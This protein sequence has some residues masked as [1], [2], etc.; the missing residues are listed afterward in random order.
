MSK[1]CRCRDQRR[2]QMPKKLEWTR[3]QC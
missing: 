3:V 1:E 2:N